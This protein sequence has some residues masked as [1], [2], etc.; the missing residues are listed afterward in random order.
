MEKPIVLL[1]THWLAE[2]MFDLITEIPECTVS[3]FIE[4]M[5]PERCSLNIEG[6]PIIWV[7]D[8]KN[9]VNTHQAI[10]ALG[11]THRDKFIEHV[12]SIGIPF[13]TLTHP[14][15]RVSSRASLGTGCFV[16]ANSI[17]ST[18]TEIGD[19]VFINRGVL[20]GHHVSVEKYCSI[21]CGVNIGGLAQ[22]GEGTYIG[23][24]AVILDRVKIGTGCIIGAGS[25]VTKDL[26]DNVQVIGVPAKIVKTD[27]QGK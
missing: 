8:L 13:A 9:M 26:P 2:E 3:A 19:H 12:E 10:C 17:V 14:S 5:D 20:V 27:V 4:N 7:D 11:S 16:S 25:V 6:L 24:S 22:I 15:S 1:G 23:M 18:K 21:Q